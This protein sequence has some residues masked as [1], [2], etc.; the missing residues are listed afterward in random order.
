[1]ARHRFVITG[2]RQAAQNKQASHIQSAAG[3]AHS[4]VRF[5]SNSNTM[6]ATLLED[7]SLYSRSTNLDVSAA[8]VG[9]LPTCHFRFR[10]VRL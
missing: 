1:M 8:I 2:P 9:F 6:N 7:D 3:P 4:K 10:Q 5:G